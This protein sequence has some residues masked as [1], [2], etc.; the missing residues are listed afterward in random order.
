[1]K[2]EPILLDRPVPAPFIHRQGCRCPACPGGWQSLDPVSRSVLLFS[3]GLAL[4]LT[5]VAA[6]GR[7]EAA[8]R[9][10]FGL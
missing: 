9:A 10:L 3:A 1:M 6:S 5:L 8:L 4:G 2:L 7:L